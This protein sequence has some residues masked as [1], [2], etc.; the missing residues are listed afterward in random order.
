MGD[1]FVPSFRHIQPH[2]NLTALNSQVHRR[3]KWVNCYAGPSRYSG[4]AE[5]E[6]HLSEFENKKLLAAWKNSAFFRK[7]H[8]DPYG[9]IRWNNDIEL[10]PD[11]L[12][13]KFDGRNG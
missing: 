12:Y 4:G 11:L 5:G 6:I 3:S 2:T 10:R 8:V 13:M 7:V 9:L 1:D